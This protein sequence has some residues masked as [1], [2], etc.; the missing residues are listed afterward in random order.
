[1]LG[2]LVQWIRIERYEPS[3]PSSNL[4]RNTKC[5]GVVAE[6]RRHFTVYEDKV[7]STPIHFAI[8][9]EHKKEKYCA[10]QVEPSKRD[11]GNQPTNSRRRLIRWP[12]R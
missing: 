10:R 6:R 7:G 4:E 1:M 9:L 8:V 5:Q 11:T 12:S 2:K 3:N